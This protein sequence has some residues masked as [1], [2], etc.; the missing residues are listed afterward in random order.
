MDGLKPCPF[1]GG[2]ARYRH[3]CGVECSDCSANVVDVR[4]NLTAAIADWNRRTDATA[5]AEARA[6]ID[7][8]HDQVGDWIVRADEANARAERLEAALR[9]IAANTCCGG[10]REAALVARA[11]LKPPAKDDTPSPSP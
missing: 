6:E 9:S 3:M 8:L 4:R 10:C 2:K 11:A 1:C 5:L 7:R